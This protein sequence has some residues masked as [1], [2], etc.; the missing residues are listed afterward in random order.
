MSITSATTAA[1]AATAITSAIGTIPKS[2]EWPDDRE[3]DALS[4]A[5]A[6]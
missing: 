6:R 3:L 2:V 5:E 4:F 1:T